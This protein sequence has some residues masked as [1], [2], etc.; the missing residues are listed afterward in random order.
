MVCCALCNFL[1]VL[2]VGE[3]DVGLTLTILLLIV[4]VNGD[5]VVLFLC[6]CRLVNSALLRSVVDMCVNLDRHIG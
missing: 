1:S 4:R 6:V 3:P 5:V 2:D